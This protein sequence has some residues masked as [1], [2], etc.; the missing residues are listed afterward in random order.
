MVIPE[1]YRVI[2]L[3][4]KVT[5]GQVLGPLNDKR[6]YELRKF[7]FP[8][9]ETMHQID[10]ESHISTHVE[11]PSHFMMARFGVEAKDVSEIPVDSFF[12][13]AIFINLKNSKPRQ[14]YSIEDLQKE[15]VKEGDIVLVGNSPHD[16]NQKPWL[17]SKATKWLADIK[18]KMIGFDRTVEVDPP[19]DPKSLKYYF[20]HEYMLSHDIPMIEVLANMQE[21]KK[22]RFFFIGIPAKMGGLDAFPIRAVVL[23][24]L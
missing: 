18:I 13:E 7:D 24:P 6:R 22:K 16:G 14:E 8:P 9:G 21:L 11:A 4:E 2:D 17:S 23:E 10:M 3:S 1:K 20:T 15:G 19:R 12:G 5:P